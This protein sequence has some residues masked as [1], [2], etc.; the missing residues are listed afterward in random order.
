MTQDSR[1]WNGTVTGDA[2][3]Y[4]DADWQE[5]YQH[6]IGWG[7]RRSNVGVFLGSG[8]QPDDGL[9]V[10]PA[11]PPDT[12]INVG[13]GAALVQ[14]LAY[15]NTAMV[16]FTIAAN[17]SGNP[18]IDTVIVRADYALQ[19]A[20]LAVLQGTPAASPSPPSLTQNAGV[21]WD[22]PLA[23]IA[24]AN[25]FVSISNSNITPRHEWV[26]A[27]PAVYLDDVQ[28]NS[29]G[30]LNTGDV[31]IWDSSANRAV[32]T[33]TLLNDPRIVGTWVG[34]TANGNYG[35]VL[36]TGIGYVKTN[37]AVTR[38]AL[39]TTNSTVKEAVASTTVNSDRALARAL[40]TT[41]GAG[42][43]LCFV[44]GQGGGNR[45]V[46]VDQKATNT[47]GGA[48]AAAAWTTRVLNTEL[49]DPDGLVTV[50][51]NQ[52]TPIAGTYRANIV[53]P[54]VSGGAGAVVRLRLRNVTAG[55]I[56]KVGPNCSLAQVNGVGGIAVLTEAIFTANGT[57]AYDVQYYLAAGARA[58]D[59]LG[60][61][62]NEATV[63]ETYTVVDLE[64]LQ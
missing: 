30:E 6:I 13:R 21:M 14:G 32:T 4:S 47:A 37:A 3:P 46:V 20:R 62:V 23:D 16:T 51:G 26:N 63:V 8:A 40:E 12:T 35:R 38:G 15:I 64:R 34:R 19:T 29:G 2:G 60:I 61:A 56:V 59:G 10:Q 44:Q 50:A 54:F 48:S 11:S 5:L 18:R 49:S 27:P 43:A 57:D 42:L 25:G 52:I 17:S 31:V 53:S 45:A 28:N 24:V 39:L 36:R 22:I 41:S 58:T 55:T 7:G 1:P 33:T 9:R